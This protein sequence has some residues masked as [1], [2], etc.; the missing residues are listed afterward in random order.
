MIIWKPV[1]AEC[2]QCVK[3]PTNKVEK[4]TVAEVRTNSHSKEEAVAHA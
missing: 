3:E 4:N 2:L 1:V